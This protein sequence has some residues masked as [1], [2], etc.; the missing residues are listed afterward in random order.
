M[1]MRRRS[2]LRVTL[3]AVPALAAIW[4]PASATP[5]AANAT[6]VPDAE[7]AGNRFAIDGWDTSATGADDQVLFRLNAS[8]STAWR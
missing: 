1:Q 2:F 6:T 5:L 3:G 8:W 4:S 7:G